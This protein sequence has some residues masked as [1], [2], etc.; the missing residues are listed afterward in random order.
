MI[1]LIGFFLLFFNI[2]AWVTVISLVMFVIGLVQVIVDLGWLSV[3]KINANLP[4][5]KD[6]YP[7]VARQRSQKLFLLPFIVDISFIVIFIYI[8]VSIL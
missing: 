4:T 7:I 3:V 8:I 6:A 1:C 2:S 5:W